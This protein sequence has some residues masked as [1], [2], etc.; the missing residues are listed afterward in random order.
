VSAIPC[1]RVLIVDDETDTVDTLVTLL[2]QDGHECAAA[3]NGAGA[4]RACEADVFDCMVLDHWLGEVNGLEVARHFL[5]SPMRPGRIILLTGTP[6]DD[7]ES[8][9]D[10]GLIDDHLQKP[11]E[12]SALVLRVRASLKA[13]DAI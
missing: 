12:P 1:A 8:A 7:F 10:D 13:R 2:E 9:L 5:D 11:A 4:I 3:Y 6:R